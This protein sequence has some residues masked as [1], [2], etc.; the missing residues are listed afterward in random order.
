MS[1][2][3]SSDAGNGAK[4]SWVLSVRLLGQV[5]FGGNCSEEI[6]NPF[7]VQVEGR[8]S[9]TSRSQIPVPT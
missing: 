2:V 3:P 8:S 7:R 5:S 4:I 6:S 1:Y 9:A